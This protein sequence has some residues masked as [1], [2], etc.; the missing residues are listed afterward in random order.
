M[1][2]LR[3][4]RSTLAQILNQQEDGPRATA[5]YDRY[6]YDKEKRQALETW[7]RHLDALIYG[8]TS[9]RI[10]PFRQ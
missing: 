10:V 3:I 2:H 8:I 1:V 9:A 5:V 4:P 6:S 7:G